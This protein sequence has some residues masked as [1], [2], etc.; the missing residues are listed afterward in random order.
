MAQSTSQLI[1]LHTCTCTCKCEILFC[2]LYNGLQP[3][4][5]QTINKLQRWYYKCTTNC[6]L[7]IKDFDILRKVS[8]KHNNRFNQSMLIN[9]CYVHQCYVKSTVTT[10]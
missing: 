4:Q 7:K 5:K 10:M 8:C 6:I 1:L 9:Q 2:K 3:T